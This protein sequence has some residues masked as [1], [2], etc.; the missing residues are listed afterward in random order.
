MLVELLVAGAILSIAAAVIL[1]SMSASARAMKRAELRSRAVNLLQRKA[2]EVESDGLSHSDSGDFA[3][4][5]P[6]FS[7]SAEPD[8]N[9]CDADLCRVT[10]TVKWNE[11]GAGGEVHLVTMASRNRSL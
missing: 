4:R 5:A 11:R 2:G 9:D 8:L 1:G 10:V 3:G 6:G 7:W